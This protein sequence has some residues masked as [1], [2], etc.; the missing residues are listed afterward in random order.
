MNWIKNLKHAQ[1]DYRRAFEEHKTASADNRYA[2]GCLLDFL[3]GKRSRE[4]CANDL[5]ERLEKSGGYDG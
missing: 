4:D 5:R 2:V 1:R 3:N